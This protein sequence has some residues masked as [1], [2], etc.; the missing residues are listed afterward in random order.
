MVKTPTKTPPPKRERRINGTLKVAAPKHEPEVTDNGAKEEWPVPNLSSEIAQEMVQAT[1]DNIREIRQRIEEAFNALGTDALPG[2]VFPVGSRNNSVEA[3]NF[4]VA[5]VLS[6]LATSRKKVAEEV[7]EKAGVFGDPESY[8]LGDTVMVFNDP[9]FSINVKMGRP[10]KMINREQV[11]AAAEKYLGKKAPEF[12][13]ECF[14]E[15]SA[16]KQIIVS[17][18]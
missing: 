10:T 6:K 18:K 15:R 16:T 11:E 5:E 2:T 8:V 1:D 3:V 9:N 14:K 4:V 12:L 13:E 7:A 17:M